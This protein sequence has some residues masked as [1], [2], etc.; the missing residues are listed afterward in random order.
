MKASVSE[1]QEFETE[2][3]G[4]DMSFD[5]E[6]PFEGMVIILWKFE[7]QKNDSSVNLDSKPF[8]HQHSLAAS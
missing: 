3:E 8:P 2:E 6:A 5:M 7:V 1:S 4:I